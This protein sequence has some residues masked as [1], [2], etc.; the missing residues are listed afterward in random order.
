M[1]KAINTYIQKFPK[2]VQ[3]IMQK[4]RKTIRS[5]VPNS[6]E[7]MSYGI[8][9]FDLHD[10]HVVHYAAFKEHIGFFPTPSPIAVFKKA[11]T[12]YKTSKGA[13]QFPYDKPI[14]YDLIKQIVVFRVK[15]ISKT[16]KEK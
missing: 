1:D 11:L 3:I 16:E 6:N 9:T 5:V 12:P 13:I 4:V 10:T 7:V 15:Q 8:P 2:E 14:P